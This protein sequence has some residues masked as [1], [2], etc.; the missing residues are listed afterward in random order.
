MI[1]ASEEIYVNIAD[2][3]Y[4]DKKGEVEVKFKYNNACRKISV[5]FL[6]LG[7]EFDPTKQKNPDYTNLLVS[8]NIGGRGILIAR[9]M[10]DIMKYS[11]TDGRNI[12]T[13]IK[14]IE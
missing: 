6:D 10:C 7:R 5:E 11:R 8:N 9:N 1:I 14:Y 3:A 12:L 2:Y 13:I 4:T